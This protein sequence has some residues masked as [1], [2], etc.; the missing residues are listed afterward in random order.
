MT[1]WLMGFLWPWTSPPNKS[2]QLLVESLWMFVPNVRK[3]PGGV[4]ELLCS[5][6]WNRHMDDRTEALCLQQWRPL[7][8]QK[9]TS[10]LF[11]TVKK[12]EKKKK[13]SFLHFLIFIFA[14]TVN[15]FSIFNFALPLRH[16]HWWAG[17]SASALKKHFGGYIV[18]DICTVD[19]P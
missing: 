2:N 9:T 5:R 13:K 12:R 11:I 10:L 18:E 17:V 4:S 8:Q 6:E 15:S 1:K 16:N 7:A 3:F 14:D 19:S